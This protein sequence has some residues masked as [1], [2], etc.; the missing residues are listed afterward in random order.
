MVFGSIAG[1]DYYI[2]PPDERTCPLL[3]PLYLDEAVR[4]PRD[5]ESS[6]ESAEAR[7]HTW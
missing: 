2:S 6:C 4:L 1:S 5:L 7:V 3:L